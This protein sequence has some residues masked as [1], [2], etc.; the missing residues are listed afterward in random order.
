MVSIASTPNTA[1]SQI[2]NLFFTHIRQSRLKMKRKFTRKL[3]RNAFANRAIEFKN[4]RKEER[5]NII[6]S[7]E[8]TY[9]FETCPFAVSESTTDEKW[10]LHLTQFLRAPHSLAKGNRN[11][12]SRRKK[13]SCFTYVCRNAQASFHTS[14]IDRQIDELGTLHWGGQEYV[15]ASMCVHNVRT[16]SSMHYCTGFASFVSLGR[17]R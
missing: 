8:R 15:Q 10:M 6:E 12:F 7:A 4:P 17:G 9:F 5:D 1:S 11:T 16:Y 14:D 13:I 3:H 2:P